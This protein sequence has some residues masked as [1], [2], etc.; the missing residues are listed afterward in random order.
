MDLNL[1]LWKENRT[2]SWPHTERLLH[3]VKDKN[4]RQKAWQHQGGPFPVYLLPERSLESSCPAWYIQVEAG[5]MA[6][7]RWSSPAWEALSIHLPFL[8]FYHLSPFLF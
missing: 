2:P 6:D 5:G 1:I 4:S 3:V 7:Q 8:M